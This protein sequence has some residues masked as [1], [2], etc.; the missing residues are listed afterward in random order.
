MSESPKPRFAIDLNE[1]ERQLAQAGAPQNHQASATRNDPLA[2]LARIVGQ[3]DPFQSILANDGSSRQRPQGASVD[4]LFAVRDTMTPAAREVPAHGSHAGQASQSYDQDGYAHQPARQDQ[5]YDEQN[6]YGN[7]AYAQDYYSDQAAQYPDQGYDDTDRLDY[8]PV[9]KT[10]SRKGPLA[11]AAVLGA[12]V[13]GGGGAYMASGSSSI[14]GGEPLLIKADNEPTKVQPQ[15]PGGVEIPNQNKQIY[16]RANQNG[17]TKV[18]NREEQPVDVQQAVRMNGNAVADATGGTVGA[19]GKPQQTASLNLGEPKKVRT[20]TIR[21]DGTTAGEA[22][23]PQPAAPAA[24]TLPPQAQSAPVQVASAQVPA[25]QPRPVASTPAAAPA[26]PVPTPKPTPAA[27][28]PTSTPAPQQ[29]ASVQP[30]APAA[31]ETAGAGGFA[32]Q[33]GVATSEAA[34]QSVFASFQRK[35]SDLGGQPSMIRKAEVNGNTVYRVRVGPMSKEEASSLCSKL[36]GQ[37]GQCFVAKN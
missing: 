21:P 1:I 2:E 3:D 9:E 12:L 13:L 34:A 37:G 4:D 32:V 24:M 23:A 27:A 11:I 33:L 7:E 31:T 36:Q 19:S 35:F 29:V 14:T 10:R 28:T 26:T 8:P 30:T 18:V 25:A 16:E 22:P 20:V 17:A 15:N 5:G 6:S